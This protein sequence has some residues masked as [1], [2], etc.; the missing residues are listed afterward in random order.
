MSRLREML[1]RAPGAGFFW[2]FGLALLVRVGVALT[3]A[4]AITGDAADYDRLARGLVEGRGYLSPSGR[5]TAWRP[6]LYAGFVAAVYEVAGESHVAVRVAQAVLGAAAAGLVYLLGSWFLGP[7]PALLAGVYATVDLASL[8]SVAR[9]LSETLFTVLL[10]LSVWLLVR[11]LESSGRAAR[12]WAFAAGV[13]LGLGALTRGVLLLYPLA[14][15]PVWLWARRGSGRALLAV[16]AGFVLTLGPWTLRNERAL[17]AFVPVATQGGLTLWAGNHPVNGWIF[18]LIPDD[19]TTRSVAGL[20]EAEASSRLA[21]A[22]ARD[23]AFHPGR[24]PKLL[25][26]KTLFFWA[27]VDWEILPRYGTFNP[28][29]TFE[30]IWSV[31]LVWLLWRAHDARARVRDAWPLWLP[32]AYLFVLAMVFYGSPRF[33]LPVE[34]LLTLGAAAGLARLGRMRGVGAAVRWALSTA[35]LVLLLT[36]AA[37][38][39]RAAARSVL[40]S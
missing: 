20:P 9:L 33:R 3:Q 29:Y 12:A 34:P 2:I 16:V 22:T 10:L 21:A 30:L 27:P 28:T 38:P 7:G 36:A 5:P 23:L 26:L 18:G 40:G 14:L 17:H 31:I 35:V 37:G 1:R 4:P 39:L 11:T 13:A 32:I 24:I 6:P 25:A 8:F 19:A 15:I